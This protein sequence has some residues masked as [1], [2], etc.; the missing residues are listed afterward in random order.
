MH[1]EVSNGEIVDKLT[2]IEIK[3]LYINDASKRINLEKEYE[4]LNKATLSFFDKNNVLYKQLLEINTKL[5]HIE[6]LCRQHE[7]QKLFNNDF[8][9]IARSVYITNDERAMIKKQINE[10]TGSHLIEEKS[11][12]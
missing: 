12:Q 2:I 8:I 10:Q 3:L 9:E 1:I 11:Y 5:W 6:D 7:Q 4:V